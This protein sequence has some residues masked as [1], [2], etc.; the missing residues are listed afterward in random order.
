LIFRHLRSPAAAVAMLTW[1]GLTAAGFITFARTARNVPLADDWRLVSP[2]TRHEPDLGAWVWADDA[3]QP[4]PLS[5][6]AALGAVVVT[7]NI[8]APGFLALLVLSAVA[9]A[10]LVALWQI[11]SGRARYTDVVIPLL[12][13]Q[14]AFWGGRPASA[15]LEAVVPLGLAT[16]LLLAIVADPVLCTRRWPV[17]AALALPLLP[18]S[19]L[20]GLTLALGIAIWLALV[21][22]HHWPPRD[23]DM[24]PNAG[25]A[26]LAVVLV[27]LLVTGFYIGQYDAE[28]WI[29]AR[30]SASASVHMAVLA[31][32]S[33][34]GPL[35]G[36][37]P[38]YTFAALTALL[39]LGGL[40]VA[41]AARR[42]RDTERY[43]AAGLAAVIVS[44]GLALLLGDVTWSFG[45]LGLVACLY[46][47]ELYAPPAATMLAS[48]AI[49]IALVAVEAPDMRQAAAGRN[50]YARQMARVTA[51]IGAGKGVGQLAAAHRDFLLPWTTP[52][53]LATGM[54]LLRRARVGELA[55]VA[56]RAAPPSA[57]PSR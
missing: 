24:S 41:V 22:W 12:L 21:G 39:V 1:L 45:V 47:W 34:A 49:L 30:P 54:E 2:L 28:S 6:L 33:A 5:Q 48:L 31:L 13:L 8:N 51:D 37:R 27:M 18:L 11:R 52:P 3:G 42:L 25:P 10:L 46:A 20:G 40:L 43:R 26:L 7:R 55:R 44:A 38:A 32:A 29:A 4:A 19:G 17:L 56:E 16:P 35:A 53:R 57:P 23:P 14:P 9:A 36:A 15:M 50:A